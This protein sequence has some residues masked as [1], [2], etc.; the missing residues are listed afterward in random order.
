MFLDCNVS[1]LGYGYRHVVLYGVEYEQS[2][3][4][5]LLCGFQALNPLRFW[6]RLF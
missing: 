3:K 6:L 1:V 2:D 5:D 4:N